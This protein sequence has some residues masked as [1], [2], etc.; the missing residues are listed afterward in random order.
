[1]RQMGTLMVNHGIQRDGH[2]CS[3]CHAADGILDYAALGYAPERV[4]ELQQMDIVEQIEASS[5]K[6]AAANVRQ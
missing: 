1:M 4:R 2:G 6:T 3:D 5:A